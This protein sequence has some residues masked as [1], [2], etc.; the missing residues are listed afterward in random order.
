MESQAPTRDLEG[1]TQSVDVEDSEID[2]NPLHAL[3]PQ[4]KARCVANESKTTP[5]PIVLL[6]EKLRNDTTFQTKLARSIANMIGFKYALYT[7][8]QSTLATRLLDEQFKFFEQVCAYGKITG[9]V[10]YRDPADSTIKRYI[11]F[12]LQP[13]YKRMIAVLEALQEKILQENLYAA[14]ETG[15]RVAESQAE[16]YEDGDA[17][18]EFGLE[19]DNKSNELERRIVALGLD[20]RIWNAKPW[21]VMIPGADV[22]DLIAVGNAV[23][24]NDVLR[25]W[26]RYVDL[27]E[28]II[29]TFGTEMESRQN[30]A[31]TL[32]NDER[33]AQLLDY[34]T[35]CNAFSARYRDY[36]TA[37]D[38]QELR[39]NFSSFYQALDEYNATKEI[40]S[41]IRDLMDDYEISISV[42]QKSD[43]N[44]MFDV[45]S[46][47]YNEASLKR[48]KQVVSISQAN[49]AKIIA[50][51]VTA[52][53]ETNPDSLLNRLQEFDTEIKGQSRQNIKQTMVDM[54]NAFANN[55]S[56]F[57]T[58][59]F[60]WYIVG[61]AGSGKTTVAQAIGPVL[62]SMGVLVFGN[63]YVESRATLVGQYV[64]ETAIKTRAKLVRS[65]ENVMFIDEAYAVAKAGSGNTK[66]DQ[67]GLECLD[68]IVGFLDK[69][70][71]QICVI[72]AGYEC[73][74]QR[75][76]LEANEGLTRRFPSKYAVEMQRLC[77]GEFWEIF[78]ADL[79]KKVRFERPQTTLND[80]LDDDAQRVILGVFY[81]GSGITGKD[82]TEGG[83]T[84]RHLLE[85]EASDAVELSQEISTTFFAHNGERL[86]SDIVG[87]LLIDW[88]KARETRGVSYE[89]QRNKECEI[90]AQYD[91]MVHPEA[92]QYLHY[93]NITLPP[94]SQPQ[95]FIELSQPPPQPQPLIERS[96][97]QSLIER[98]QTRRETLSPAGLGAALTESNDPVTYNDETKS[99][100]ISIPGEEPVT[101]DGKICRSG[102]KE[103]TKPILQRVCQILSLNIDTTQTTKQLNAA[104]KSIL[105]TKKGGSLRRRRR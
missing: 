98:L 7:A 3:T 28:E 35:Q 65:L 10:Y 16:A 87:S 43:N 76:F 34:N 84:F 94:V 90:E 73:M 57:V 39:E 8:R 14:D 61:P 23:L 54:I 49:L 63:F 6:T 60:N 29:T 36:G 81:A 103:A 5:S 75:Y 22:A 31:Q 50:N 46:N 104:I 93:R 64:G 37:P 17:E 83:I 95:P 72:V 38:E 30:L 4:Y 86:D 24:N 2:T 96:Q 79:L 82:M 25:M 32:V 9:D 77:P 52:A 56:Q 74:M 11:L 80:V 71:G 66:F 88:L 12:E 13:Q 40:T 99:W 47:R 69:Y 89:M 62:A 70:Q 68:E 1:L 55:R 92:L 85:N 44:T 105:L 18:I 67:F 58:G 20:R 91:L 101:F 33:W 42:Q 100:T 27:T 41:R 15:G 48:G 21:R 102:R 26:N 59:Y 45:Q 78:Q 19:L 97:P 51:R 53:G